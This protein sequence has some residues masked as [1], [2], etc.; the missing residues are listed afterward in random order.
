MVV[1]VIIV[2]Y[3]VRF[4]LE[5]CLY[6]VQKALRGWDAEIFVV[7][8]HSDDGSVDYLRP[9][10]P[11]VK[12][13]ENAENKGF[14]AANNQALALAGGEYVLFLNPDTVLPEDFV[15]KSLA[16]FSTA[17]NA[18]GVGVRMIDGSGR[19]LKESR[20]GYP[21]P[22]AAF[23]KLSGLAG[24]FPRSRYFSGY[25]LGHLEENMTAA[26]P[27]LSGACLWVRREVL[28]KTGGFDERFF[29]YAEDIDLSYRLEKAGYVNYYLADTTIIHF[30]GEST[31]KDMRYIRQ[32]YKA[33]SQFHKKHSRFPAVFNGM[34]EAGIRLRAAVS[35]AGRQKVRSTVGSK[36][37]VKTFV[38]GDQQETQ[39][40]KPR[41]FKGC[42]RV[43][44]SRKQDALDI[45]FCEGERFS[46]KDGIEA[47]EKDAFDRNK[48]RV[49]FHASGGLSIA[50]SAERDE[51]GEALII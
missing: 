44:V 40:L 5:L 47:L 11:G 13:I 33:M 46:F 49:K 37:I 35:M 27:V 1:S 34:V 2:N 30:K 32:F 42:H 7:D 10:F 21:T 41:L 8:N 39:G 25:Y 51:Q 50:G 36:R 31:R 19:F 29:M 28:E 20:R 48:Q 23:C 38:T 24:C 15:G 12:F 9:L 3:R 18:G 16:F 43:A 6:S 14:G 26:A 17:A 4:F 22:W 45:I